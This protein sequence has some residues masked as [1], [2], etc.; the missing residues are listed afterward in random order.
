MAK[1]GRRREWA[2]ATDDTD[3]FPAVTDDD[4]ESGDK[5]EEDEAQPAESNGS[6]E[7]RSRA[8]R[9]RQAVVD[10]LAQLGVAIVAG[11]ALCVSFP[12]V[13]LVVHGHRGVRLAG[14]GADP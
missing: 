5:D 14:L 2:R 1:S 6:T 12:A 3:I 11:L 4:A 13:R 8:Q 9:F 10:R 7:V